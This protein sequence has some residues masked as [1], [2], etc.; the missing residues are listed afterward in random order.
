MVV[1]TALIQ[2]EKGCLGSLIC[3]GKLF[4]PLRNCSVLVLG[5][6]RGSTES[7]ESVIK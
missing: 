2:P 7:R 6:G 4:Y 3:I 5:S 1:E